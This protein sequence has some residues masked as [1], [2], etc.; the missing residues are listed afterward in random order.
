MIKSLFKTVLILLSFSIVSCSENSDL[1]ID[2]WNS[3]GIREQTY[4]TKNGTPYK[5]VRGGTIFGSYITNVSNETFPF[6]IEQ[7]D[8]SIAK[9]CGLK[10]GKYIA[11][12]VMLRIS[13]L[14][15]SYKGL[16]IVEAEAVPDSELDVEGEDDPNVY[17]WLPEY[18]ELSWNSHEYWTTKTKFGYRVSL[19]DCTSVQEW[20]PY[21]KRWDVGQNVVCET[22]A[23]RIISDE[24]GKVYPS[25]TTYPVPK[26]ECAFNIRCYYG[27]NIAVRI[28]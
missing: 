23:V 24:N 21:Y 12:K 10:P 15:P 4:K 26:D 2:E 17:G 27:D 6:V 9:M 25:W 5:Y 11:Q 22:A 7:K 16:E 3:S 19:K 20:N 8:A 13:W 28:R 1:E 14:R 18:V